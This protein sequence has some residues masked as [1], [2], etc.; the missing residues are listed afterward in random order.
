MGNEGAAKVATQPDQPAQGVEVDEPQTP[1]DQKPPET[2]G[3][4]DDDRGAENDE[5]EPPPPSEVDELAKSMGWRPKEKFRGDP[6]LWKP[7]DEYIRAGA[8]IQRG[9]SRD[10]KELRGTVETMTKTQGAILEQTLAEQRDRLIAKYNRAVED[11]DAQTSFK[12]GRQIDELNGQAQS[13]TAPRVA[14]PPPEAQDWVERNGWFNQDPLARTLALNVAEQYA[15]AG[16]SPEAQ[17]QA[18]ER[19]VRRVY[20]HLFGASSKPPPGVEPPGGRSGSSVKKGS[21]YA[22]LPKEA[23]AVAK[24]MAERGVIPNVEAYAKQYWQNQKTGA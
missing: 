16:H 24:D 4:D 9:L 13:L 12:V 15:N 2:P 17:L 14:P 18:A 21:T 8:E 3:G 23:K 11:G 22:D 7:A 10:L 1:P 6:N 20:P 19:E 5:D